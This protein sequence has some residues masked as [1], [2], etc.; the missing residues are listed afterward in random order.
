MIYAELSD[1]LVNR[2]IHHK[3]WEENG[4]YYITVF[5]FTGYAPKTWKQWADACQFLISVHCAQCQLHNSQDWQSVTFD[6]GTVFDMIRDT[7][8]DL[9]DFRTNAGRTLFEINSCPVFPYNR[10]T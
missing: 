1:S 9:F 8:D 2:N 6:L 3:I 7:P 10:K 5:G 4:R